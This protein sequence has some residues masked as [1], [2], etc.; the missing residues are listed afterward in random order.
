[1]KGKRFLYI[2]IILA[3]VIAGIFLIKKNQELRRRAAGG[4]PVAQIMLSTSKLDE[5]L[6]R[7]DV[8]FKTG[9]EGGNLEKISSLSLRLK[10]PQDGDK[11]LLLTDKNGIKT[12]KIYPNEN[13][14]NSDSWKFP[15]NKI[16]TEDNA[17]NIDFAAVNLTTEGYS[18]KDFEKI[19]SFYLKLGE[20]KEA[21]EYRL[22][23]AKD[24]SAIMTKTKPV[25]NIL[26]Y[27]ENEFLTIKV[28]FE[29]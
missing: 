8:M 26:A 9:S 15:V 23:V 16:Y 7:V 5:R 3:G 6:A 20:N 12:D 22:T 17:L 27:P 2:T 13:F 18:A 25:T 28:S 24:E 29:E 11:E 4:E 21:L 10:Y 1:M 14:V 19:A